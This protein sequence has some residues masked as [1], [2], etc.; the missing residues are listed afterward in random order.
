LSTATNTK[1][2]TAFNAIASG[3][4]SEFKKR[5]RLRIKLIATPKMVPAMSPTSAFIPDT[6][7]ASQIR[8][9]LLKKL[10]KIFDGGARKYG[11]SS[12]NFTAPSQNA[13]NATPNTN[14][15]AMLRSRLTKVMISDLQLHELL[16]HLHDLHVCREVLRGQR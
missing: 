1:I 15:T 12:K 10:L 2:G 3:V 7:A 14:G 6:D 4:M 8:E 13:R 9:A 11:F 5:K 16:L